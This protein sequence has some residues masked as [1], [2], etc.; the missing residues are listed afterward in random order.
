LT[1]VD[2][3]YIEAV[4]TQMQQKGYTLVNKDADPDLAI[5]VNRIFNS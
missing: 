3:A 1:S 4:K 5:S 2:A